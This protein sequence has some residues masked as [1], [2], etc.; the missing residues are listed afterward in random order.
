MSYGQGAGEA[1]AVRDGQGV[2]HKQS[3]T[4]MPSSPLPMQ[5]GINPLKKLMISYQKMR[6]LRFDVINTD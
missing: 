4:V 5:E 3:K 1:L 6:G 2:G